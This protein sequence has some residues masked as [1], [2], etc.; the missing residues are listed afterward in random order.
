VLCAAI[1]LLGANLATADDKAALTAPPPGGSPSLTPPVVLTHTLSFDLARSAKIVGA[2]CLLNAKGHVFINS[3]GPAEIM[4]VNVEGLPAN[5]DFDFFVIQLPNAPFGLSWYQG[6]IETN[7][8]GQGH[9]TFIGRF[10]IETFIVAPGSGIAPQV[11][12]NAFPDEDSNPATGPVHTF[13]LGL[14]FNAP[15]DA[16]RAGCPGDVTPFNGEHDAGIQVLSTRNFPDARG[17]LIGLKP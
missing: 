3:L 17:P 9:G 10:N 16:V 15:A 13:H 8:N 4:Q 1:G 2:K 6:D 14:W 11:H 7:R 12:D 5:T